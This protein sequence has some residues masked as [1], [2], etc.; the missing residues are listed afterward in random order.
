MEIDTLVRAKPIIR[1]LV[2]M[3]YREKINDPSMHSLFF[4]KGE[5]R[6]YHIGWCLDV[7]YFHTGEQIVIPVNNIIKIH[8][9]TN[10]F[11][12]EIKEKRKWVNN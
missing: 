4:I 8:P 5:V 6:Q 12:I 1:G 3:E 9:V 11:D 10:F 7:F 2:I